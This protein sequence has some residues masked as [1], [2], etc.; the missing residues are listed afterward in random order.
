MSSGSFRGLPFPPMLLAPLPKQLPEGTN[1]SECDKPQSRW[2]LQPLPGVAPIC[3]LCVLYEVPWDGKDPNDVDAFIRAVEEA[4]DGEFERDER[5]RLA[6]CRDA[7]R[8]VASLVLTTKV[9]G[10]AGKGRR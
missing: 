4:Q 1:C 10:M 3:S 5:G 6:S 7:D 9:I 8:L 2:F